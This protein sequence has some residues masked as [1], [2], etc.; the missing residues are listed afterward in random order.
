MVTGSGA[1]VI[2]SDPTLVTV[3]TLDSQ[4]NQIPLQVVSLNGATGVIQISDLLLAGTPLYATYYFKRTDTLVQNQDLSAQI[5]AFASL[6]FQGVTLGLSQPGFSGNSVTLALTLAASSHGVAD[7]QAVSGNG[8]DAISIELR[9]PDNA[10]RTSYDLMNL[11]SAGINTASGGQL[12]FV[13][14]TVG[15]PIV[16]SALTATPP[17][18]AGSAR[19]PTPPSR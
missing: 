14:P 19:T 12:T 2:A 8:S 7:Q 11:I 16:L 18:P 3:Y 1:G 10:I 9:L 5:P 13:A 4:A 17:S 15:A 6:I